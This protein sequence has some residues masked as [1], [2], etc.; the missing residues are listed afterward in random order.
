M[1]ALFFSQEN[2]LIFLRYKKIL[3]SKKLA[4]ALPVPAGEGLRVYVEVAVV[5]IAPVV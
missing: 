4:G 5:L 2:E 3:T 1:E